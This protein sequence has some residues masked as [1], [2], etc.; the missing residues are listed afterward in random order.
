MTEKNARKNNS[1][2]RRSAARLAAVQ[3]LYEV[4]L[5]GAT[6]D[7]VLSDFLDHGIGAKTLLS[8]GEY[9]P[10]VEADLAEPDKV[11]FAAILR[12]VVAR[13]AD[14]DAMIDGALSGEWSVERLEAV[15]RAILRAGAFELATR[16]DI[17]PRVAISEYVDVAKAFFAG[18]EPGLVNAVLDRIAKVVRSDDFGGNGKA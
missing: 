6:V 12:G 2:Q 17:P 8:Q 10:E 13:Q 15:L 4:E 16:S 11:L 9:E 3:G 14:F 1:S 5:N 18:P 7:R